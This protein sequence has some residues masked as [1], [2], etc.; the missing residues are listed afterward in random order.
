MTTLNI[1]GNFQPT[2]TNNG[3][4]LPVS[5]GRATSAN[6]RNDSGSNTVELKAVSTAKVNTIKTN[7]VEKAAVTN[8]QRT[9]LKKEEVETQIEKLQEFTQSIDRSLQFKV[10]EE[11]GVTIVRVVDKETDELIRQFPPEE[12]LNLSRRLK[13]LNEQNTG[14]SGVLLQEKV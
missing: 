10:D 14:N 7:N 4:P 3:K 13:E 6:T 9:D 2:S 12:L 5:S 8:N 1:A 11:L